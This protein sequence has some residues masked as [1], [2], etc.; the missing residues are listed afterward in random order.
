LYLLFLAPWLLKE[1]LRREDLAFM[2]AVGLGLLLFFIGREPP[3][4]TAPNP[5]R[6]NV[7]ALGS[8]ICWA[9]A[10]CGLRWL[11][12]DG[13]RG[14]PAAAVVSGNLTAF[15]VA[16]PMALPVGPH[17]PSDWTLILYLGVFQI[18]LAYV[19]VTAAIQVVAALEASVILLIEPVLNPLW[20]WVIQ[21]ETPG[22]WP[23]IGGVI[24]IGAT[25]VKSWIEGRDRVTAPVT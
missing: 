21:A 4:A 6:G 9:L 17:M 1:R 23:L 5:L 8:G 3:I 2:V 19:F 11:G 13:R 7:L 20:A 16:L 12:T 10:I 25:T 24:I 14:S 18:A 22:L 15:L